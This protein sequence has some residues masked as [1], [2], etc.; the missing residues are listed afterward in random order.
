MTIDDESQ[1]ADRIRRK[2]ERQAKR[3]RKDKN[4]NRIAIEKNILDGKE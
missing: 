3:S 2:K 4:K 1:A